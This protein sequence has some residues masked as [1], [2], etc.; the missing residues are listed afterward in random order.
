MKLIKMECP[1]C[2]G[3]LEAKEGET[4]ITCPYCGK[5]A[6]V[7]DGIEKK[8]T[9]IHIRDEAKIRNAELED[10]KYR[11]QQRQEEEQKIE[12]FKRGKTGKFMIIFMVLCALGMLGAFKGHKIL[13]G[14]IA[15]IQIVLL[16]TSW[17]IS[18]GHIQT[19][20]GIKV[21][22]FVVT[23]LACLL[24]IPY[25]MLY[26]V[27]TYE[28]YI[29]PETEITSRL[30]KPK[31]SYGQIV[32]STSDTFEVTVEKTKE[33]DYRNYL[34][35]CR[36][37]FKF[38]VN[39]QGAYE[40]YDADGY[41]L[42]LEYDSPDS[43]MVILAEAPMQMN[44]L[45]W[46]INELA[47]QLPQPPSSQG[48]VEEE[49]SEYLE[50][51]IGNVNREAYRSYADAVLEAGFQKDYHRD[52]TDFRGYNEE[53]YFVRIEDKGRNTMIITLRA[54][55]EE[56]PEPEVTDL[57]EETSAPQTPEP[58]AEPTPEP[59]KEPEKAQASGVRPEFRK[60]ME[61]Y[62]S[63]YDQYI[64][65]MI[66]YQN[67]DNAMAMMTDYLALMGKLAEWESTI[68]KIDES[69]LTT[70]EAILFNEVNL[71]VASKLNKAALTMN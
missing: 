53:G 28:K 2:S 29:W 34:S 25:V 3:Q 7:D 65:F 8:E 69:E 47:Q 14:L 42:K 15:L 24:I 55:R 12:R 57:P 44:E 9:T 31:S 35:A 22:P 60:L 63:F 64:D 17:L 70:E 37:N 39:E 4:E 10:R 48:I 13:A 32:R 52:E 23:L 38:D 66:K 43:R 16:G 18:T 62:E 5:T 26:N 68:D 40:A 56:T 71:R 45:K 20:K 50:V 51:L 21:P 11:Q 41:Y 58:A 27:Q 54:P 33:T 1:Y 67:S 36:E 59:T 46:P 30:P 61:D 49:S 6:H 19:I